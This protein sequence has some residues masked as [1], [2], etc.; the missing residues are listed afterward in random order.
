M[1][2]R[3]TKRRPHDLQASRAGAVFGGVAG[4]VP[5]MI[6][7]RLLFPG[8]FPWPWAEF[9][10][11]L[12]LLGGFGGAFCGLFGGRIGRWVRD[13]RGGAWSDYRASLAGGYVGGLL[14]GAA[15]L[16]G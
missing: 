5:G 8:R 10:L 3:A 4:F 1:N 6:L 13:R 2:E 7:D 12:V 14:G 11:A 16:L 15:T 9:A